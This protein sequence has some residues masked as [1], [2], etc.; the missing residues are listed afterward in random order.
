MVNPDALANHL[1]VMDAQACMAAEVM[2]HVHDHTNAANQDALFSGLSAIVALRQNLMSLA[3]VLVP[4]D[5]P[6]R[7]H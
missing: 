2:S 5:E 4:H 3:T 7:C 6:G 1:S